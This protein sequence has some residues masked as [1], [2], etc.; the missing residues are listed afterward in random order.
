VD[1]P[2]LE[3]RKVQLGQGRTIEVTVKA[4][5]LMQ[6]P[7]YIGIGWGSQQ[8]NGAEIWFCTINKDEFKDKG[9]LPDECPRNRANLGETMFSCCVAPGTL[10]GIPRCAVPGDEI[11]YPIEVAESCLTT[12]SSSVTIHA[13]VCMDPADDT[14]PEGPPLK[15]PLRNCF[16]LSSTPNGKMDFIVSYNPMDLNRPHGYQRR[17]SAQ[18]DLFAGVLTQRESLVTDQGLLATHAVF[19][20]AAWMIF[21]PLGIFVSVVNVFLILAC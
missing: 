19:M 15:D 11:F 18:V 3:D 14:S 9:T 21:A 6:D 10:H 7:G 5:E 1:D 2:S 12:D 20:L 13:P 17:T 4:N 8:M 16:R